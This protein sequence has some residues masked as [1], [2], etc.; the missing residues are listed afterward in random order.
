MVHG[1]SCHPAPSYEMSGGRSAEARKA[2]AEA[3]Q[4]R[5]ESRG[6]YPDKKSDDKSYGSWGP[7]FKNKQNFASLHHC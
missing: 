7:T 3:H 6:K 2:G 1:G 5:T 4:P